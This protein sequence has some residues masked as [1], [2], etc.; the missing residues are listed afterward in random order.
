MKK[1]GFLTPFVFLALLFGAVWLYF[2]P[3]LALQRLQDAA[4]A[5]DVETMNELVDF[6]ALR[7]SVKTG[8]STAVARGIGDEGN[9]LARVGG[10]LAGTLAAP[11]VN[12]FVSPEGIAALTQGRRPDQGGR[13]GDGDDDRVKVEGIDVERGYESMDRFVVRFVDE[14]SG[15]ERVSL[16]MRREGI[17][18]W[19]L[20]G[21]RLPEEEKE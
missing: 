21:V 14:E 3:Y 11:L 2:T 5:G 13:S 17:A 1:R 4:E 8:V 6:P 15:K 9:P 10:M 18:G 19:K 12:T 20:S 16:V 7:Q